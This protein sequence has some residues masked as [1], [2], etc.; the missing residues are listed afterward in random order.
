M[1]VEEPTHAEKLIHFTSRAQA[2]EKIQL[3]QQAKKTVDVQQ[4]SIL[5]KNTQ[6]IYETLSTQ[7]DSSSRISSFKP[8]KDRVHLA[9]SIPEKTKIDIITLKT[10]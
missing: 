7:K 1:V 6:K 3:E 4:E 9:I 5:Q 10:K 8:L 2:L